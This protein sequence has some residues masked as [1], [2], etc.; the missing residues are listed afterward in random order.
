MQIKCFI[1][2]F[3]ISYAISGKTKDSTSNNKLYFIGNLNGNF[4]GEI[5]PKNIPEVYRNY[6]IRNIGFRG[7]IGYTS[8]SFFVEY[9][10]NYLNTFYNGS[11]F[12]LKTNSNFYGNSFGIGYAKKIFS[13][14]KLMLL[15]F[16]ELMVED[17]RIRDGFTPIVNYYSYKLLKNKF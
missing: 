5:L 7:G 11:V 8:K 14:S 6:S 1:L 3:F 4:A 15:P 2:S 12:G 9:N 16:V 13:N 10:L 17:N